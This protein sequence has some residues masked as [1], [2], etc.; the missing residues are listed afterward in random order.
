MRACTHQFP[1]RMI[2]ACKHAPYGWKAGRGARD[3]DKANLQK[4]W[5]RF[6]KPH[7]P[8]YID[9]KP[10]QNPRNC[11][12]KRE[13]K[14]LPPPRDRAGWTCALVVGW[15]LLGPPA[16]F[17]PAILVLGLVAIV[18]RFADRR[19]G[20]ERVYLGILAVVCFGSSAILVG[21]HRRPE[22]T[23][24]RHTARV[25]SDLNRQFAAADRFKN[26]EVNTS[27][28]GASKGVVRVT[29]TV[30]SSQDLE[31]AEEIIKANGV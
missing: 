20:R 18:S 11:R 23:E 31:A 12:E 9:M 1:A 16:G 26:L 5:E 13:T 29:G 24:W 27:L 21:L 8:R 4:N 7:A 3:C 15:Q 30:N 28:P 14:T 19:R 17:A 6:T 25:A 10:P 2:G 22:F